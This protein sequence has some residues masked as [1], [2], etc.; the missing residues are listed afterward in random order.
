MQAVINIM[1]PVGG[2]HIREALGQSVTLLFREYTNAMHLQFNH[3]RY[4]DGTL[5]KVLGEQT[6]DSSL[7]P[8]PLM[9]TVSLGGR[10]KSGIAMSFD[11]YSGQ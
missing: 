11:I 9:Q 5:P 8:L 2:A 6:L 4:D 10:L 1:T 3:Y 7:R